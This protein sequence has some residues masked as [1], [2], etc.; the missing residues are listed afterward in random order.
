MEPDWSRE[1]LQ[2]FWDPSR[3]LLKSVRGYQAARWFRRYWVLRHR[4]WSV[5]TGADIPINCQIGG[6]LLMPHPNGI[7]IH[8][9]AKIGANCLI[10]HQVTVGTNRKPGAPTLGSGVDIGPGTYILG[11]VTIGNGAVIG[12]GSVVLRD[13]AANAV[14]YGVPAQERSRS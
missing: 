7:V 14:A 9:E 6:G 11:P 1:E 10:M 3:Q 2:R 12:A 5:V 8:P 4:F 13:V